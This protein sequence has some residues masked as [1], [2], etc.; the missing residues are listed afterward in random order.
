[1]LKYSMM[2]YAVRSPLASLVVDFKTRLSAG[3]L[4]RVRM[5][6]SVMR[7]VETM[8]DVTEIQNVLTNDTHLGQLVPRWW[9]QLVAASQRQIAAI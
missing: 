9:Q 4:E 7:H 3:Q 5:C 8:D 1:M 2:I 6:R